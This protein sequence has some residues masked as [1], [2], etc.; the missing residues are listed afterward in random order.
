V[1]KKRQGVTTLLKTVTA[2]S[3]STVNSNVRTSDPNTSLPPP[4]F[5]VYFKNPC[6]R[7]S[8]APPRSGGRGIQRGIFLSSCARA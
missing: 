5:V 2:I 3:I 6:D 1:P 8:E 4:S 7:L